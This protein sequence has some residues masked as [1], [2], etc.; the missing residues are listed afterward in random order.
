MSNIKITDED[1]EQRFNKALESVKKKSQVITWDLLAKELNIS[2]Q[3]FFISYKEFIK[4]ES[5][6]KRV[7]IHNDLSNIV[8]QRNVRLVSTTFENLKSPLELKC[9][10]PAHPPYFFTATAIKHGSFA[11]PC[12]P[13]PKVG[14]PKKDGLAIARDIAKKKGG[15]CLSD[16]YTDN[17]TLM[18]WHCGNEY[19][20]PWK[21]TLQNVH[22]LKSWCPECGS[23][24]K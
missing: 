7:A 20:S 11:C 8:Q 9:S 5:R 21:A 15:V 16:S 19:H 18:T 23:I 6:K 4:E 3:R 14:R 1:K 22:N 17:N 2:R 13:K 10:N 12:C 24:K